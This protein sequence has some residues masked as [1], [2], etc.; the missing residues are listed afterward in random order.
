MKIRRI[1]D[2]QFISLVEESPGYRRIE[3]SP[4]FPKGMDFTEEQCVQ[5]CDLD[6]FGNFYRDRRYNGIERKPEYMRCPPD[7]AAVTL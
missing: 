1:K 4:M 6:F 2:G 7:S 5:I 3:H